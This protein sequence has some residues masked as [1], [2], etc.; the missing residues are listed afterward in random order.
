VTRLDW[1]ILAVVVGTALLGLWQGL[2][3]GVL[4]AAGVVVG[5]LAG[6]RLAPHVLPAGSESPYTPLVA[7]IAMAL[8]SM[9]FFISLYMQQVL[10]YDALKAGLSYLPLA[11][12]IIVSAGTP[13]RAIRRPPSGES[14]IIGAV[15][16]RIRTPVSSA[17][18]PRPVCR[19]CGCRNISAQ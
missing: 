13:N 5:A 15:T 10:G 18:W 4:S 3:L 17:L 11:V 8:F 19:N 12:T 7:L 2:T 14:A 9:F 6:A 16:G 1:I